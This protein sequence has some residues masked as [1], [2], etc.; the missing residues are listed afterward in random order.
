MRLER[1]WDP[2]PEDRPI[3]WLSPPEIARFDEVFDQAVDRCLH[4]GSAGIFLSGGLDS[5][6]I[7][8]VATDRARR[9][10]R[11]P[12]QALSLGFPDPACDERVLQ[13]AVARDLGIRQQLIGF[14]EAVG[15]GSVLEQSLALSQ[16]SDAPLLNPW[17]PAYLELAQR[18][19]RS[20]AKV[21]LTGQGGD[22]WL[23]V[24]PFLSADLIRRGAVLQL[25]RFLGTLQRSYQ[26]RSFD[27]A[28]SALWRCGLRPLAGLWR[29]RLMPEAHKTIRLKSLVANDPH[30]IAPDQKLRAEQ[31]SR[32][33]AA[34]THPDPAQ[35]FYLRE[36]RRGIDH[37]LT[38]WEMEEQHEFGRRIGVHFL[39]PYCDPDLVELLYRAPP[40][41]L[42]EGGRTKGLV[43]G[44]LARR[45]PTLGFERQRKVLATSYFQSQLTREG[46]DLAETAG[47]FPALSALG[48][49]DG[50]ETRAFVQE[51]L[52]QPGQKLRHIWEVFN[53]EAWVRSN[54]GLS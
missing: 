44:T 14:D 24:T 13:A 32:A 41:V 6:S 15:A 30:W 16:K 12:P 18:G 17:A 46:P 26:L 11:S 21:I 50:R 31:H 2:A 33:E 48:V 53:L 9:M 25:A 49:V 35:G 38:S 43:R 3:Q 8:A 23:T 20:G 19:Q 45:F 39:Y 40:E 27:L 36:L 5:I 51:E 52:E 37:T 28:R 1:Y 22:E 47:D 4:H 10:G 7:A 54:G 29:H 42:N 34:L